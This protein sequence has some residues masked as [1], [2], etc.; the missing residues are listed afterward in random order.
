MEQ[1]SFC[2]IFFV[3]MGQ[4]AEWILTAGQLSGKRS[5][6]TDQ[7]A[8]T[9]PTSTQE[10]GGGAGKQQLNGM[11]LWCLPLT[12]YQLFNLSS[13]PFIP[14]RFH[15]QNFILNKFLHHFPIPQL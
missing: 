12:A 13:G 2:S 15:R 1:T 8:H 10:H 9:S 11:K 7:Q 5:Y 6:L 4:R 3:L 14:I